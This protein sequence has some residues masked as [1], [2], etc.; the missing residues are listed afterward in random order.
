MQ[1]CKIWGKQ[2]NKL[3][4][5][6]RSIRN[7]WEEGRIQRDSEKKTFLATIYVHVLWIKTSIIWRGCKI[8]STLFLKKGKRNSRDCRSSGSKRRERERE[9]T[10]WKQEM[11]S[12]FRAKF[13]Y[14]RTE[15]I[16]SLWVEKRESWIKHAKIGWIFQRNARFLW[17]TGN[18]VLARHVQ[19]IEF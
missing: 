2:Q 10:I 19:R 16:P 3:S 11:I 12:Y 17:L 14:A 4:G 5:R 18:Y 1:V 7:E 6:K 9:K 15:S 13:Q 8:S